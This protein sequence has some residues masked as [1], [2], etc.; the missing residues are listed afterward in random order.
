MEVA[1]QASSTWVQRALGLEAA[2]WVSHRL[3]RVARY[4]LLRRRCSRSKRYFLSRAFVLSY[5]AGGYL[6]RFVKGLIQD[7]STNFAT[8]LALAIALWFIAY[9]PQ[10]FLQNAF[11]VSDFH[12][13]CAG[14][15]GTALALVLTLSIVPAQKAADV[16]SSAILQLY[17]RDRV[18]WRVFASLAFLTLVSV[19]LGTDWTFG[20]DA[21]WTIA[22]QLILLGFAL[23][24]LRAFYL[25]TLGLLNPQT[26]LAL[27]RDECGR[28]IKVMARDAQR[29][30]RIIEIS[31]VRHGALDSSSAQWLAF[32]NSPASQYLIGWMDQLEEFAHKAIAR[33][34]TQAANAALTT[35]AA[36]GMQYAEVRRQ[37]IVLVPEFGGGMPI[38]VSDVREVLNPIYESIKSLCEDAAR[39]PN[40]AVVANCIREL[41]RMAARAMTLVHTQ[42]KLWS[43][44]PLSH[45]PIFYMKV[46]AMEAMKAKMD[47][48]LLAAVRAVRLVFAKISSKVRTLEAEATALDCVFEVALGSYLRNS[49]PPADEAVKTMLAIAGHELNVRGYGYNNNLKTIL[50]NIAA[51]VPL[52]VQWD[53][54]GRRMAQAFAP[55]APGSGLP[56]LLLEEARKIEAADRHWVD[57]FHDFNELSRELVMHYRHL[58]EKVKFDGVILERWVA[59]SALDCA[60]LHV[61]LLKNPP[62][63]TEAHLE[64]VENRL[65]WFIHAP[66]FFFEETTSD[67]FPY[68]QVED[69]AGRLA[70]LGMRLLQLKRTDAAKQC[71]NAI[72]SLGNSAVKV[73]NSKSYSVADIFDKLEPLARAA[74]ALGYAA[75]AVECRAMERREEIEDKVPGYAEAIRNRIGHL[76]NSL[77]R[78]SPRDLPLS[79]DP[80]P[81]LWRILRQRE[82]SG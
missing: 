67:T 28:L 23:D 10:S 53:K 20:L 25:R 35:M 82:R 55:Y 22:L 73:P 75:F 63:G 71:A 31:D 16:F 8:T 60:D 21:R 72:A 47:D 43:T 70:I 4:R 17:A 37:S 78:H 30:A 40:E 57:P 26:A 19:L 2:R 44:A 59:M 11:D 1:D 52:E 77:E 34:D 14:I 36:I 56:L 80:V 38:G 79:D 68:H 45:S 64:E 27:V 29:M 12:L 15:I 46:C 50:H 42:D 49:S 54:A 6:R 62:L 5:R 3:Q 58:A 61:Q 41:G 13:A 32:Q 66:A 18:L 81:L 48:A 74:E 65:T 39:Q 69:V 9:A 33:R 51:L 7:L 76:D 24:R